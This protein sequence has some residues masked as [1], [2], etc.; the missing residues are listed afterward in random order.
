MDNKKISVIMP[1]YNAEKYL[2]MAI[3]SILNQTY[4]NIELICVDDCSHDKSLTIL[5]DYQKQD[6]RIIIIKNKENSGPAICR[7]KGI[8]ASSGKYVAFIDND[9]WYEL[10]AL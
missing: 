5:E 4:K 6:S 3:E 1:V 7:D 8:N 10:D 9:D 2:S